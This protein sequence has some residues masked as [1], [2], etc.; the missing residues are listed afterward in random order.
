MHPDALS[1]HRPDAAT[2]SMGHPDT[3]AE[4]MEVFN[5]TEARQGAFFI[6]PVG[7]TK[8]LDTRNSVRCPSAATTRLVHDIPTTSY[9]RVA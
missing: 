9:R 7:K 8:V 6:G 2:F 3:P 5:M 4:L 1:A